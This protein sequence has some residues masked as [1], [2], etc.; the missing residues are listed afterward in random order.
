MIISNNNENINFTNEILKAKIKGEKQIC[1]VRL[2][3]VAFIS[4]MIVL[5][6]LGLARNDAFVIG[7]EV[8]AAI[9]ELIISISLLLF[10]RKNKKYPLFLE[11]IIPFFDILAVSMVYFSSSYGYPVVASVTPIPWLY[12]FFTLLS[13]RRFS[14]KSS[15]YVGIVALVFYVSISLPISMPLYQGGF[16]YPDGTYQYNE[17]GRLLLHNVKG[18]DIYISFSILEPVI[19]SFVIFSSGLIA[20]LIGKHMAKKI[21]DS[22][23]LAEEQTY[24]REQL[25]T[26]ISMSVNSSNKT[27][28]TISTSFSQISASTNEMITTLKSINSNTKEQESAVKESIKFINNM[29]ITLTNVNKQIEEQADNIKKAGEKSKNISDGVKSINDLSKEAKSS[30]DKLSKLTNEGRKS[31]ESNVEAINKISKSSKE[32]KKMNKVIN[33]ISENTNVLAINASIEAA[34]T[35]NTGEGFTIIA[36]QIRELANKASESTKKINDA[37][38]EILTRI[39]EGIVSSDRVENVFNRIIENSE[40]SAEK[41]KQISETSYVQYESAVM[42]D[43][44]IYEITDSIN[45]IVVQVNKEQSMIKT[46]FKESDKIFEL[47]MLTSN[48]INEQTIAGEDIIQAT[49]SLSEIIEE[50]KSISESMNQILDGVKTG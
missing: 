24:L 38:N 28:E 26:S 48:A 43:K 13:A 12:I 17:L 35:G 37:I 49:S 33:S 15:L 10:F 46:I 19:K 45:N 14:L 11:Y 34:N 9:I 8:G 41:V 21:Y 50:N 3:M 2:F 22:V 31:I 18:K 25:Q 7:F 47:S 23:K 16:V 39:E 30:V 36:N 42:I 4:I 29:M 40:L 1:F 27:S 44:Y 20:G 32:I 5:A 6:S